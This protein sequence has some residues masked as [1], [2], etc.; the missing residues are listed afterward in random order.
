MNDVA[1]EFGISKK[2]LY[3]YFFDK[4]DLV[5]HVVDYFM[6]PS[7]HDLNSLAEANAIDSMLKIRK[8]VVYILKFYNNH[9]EDDLK[10]TYPNIYKEVYETKR[11]RI[12]DYT[13]KNLNRGIVQGL[14]R[15]D[16]TPLFVAKLQLGQMLYTLNPAYTIF[17]ESEIS[18]L[19]LFNN[20]MNYYMHAICTNKGFEYYTKQLNKVQD[21]NN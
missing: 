4:Q 7:N 15:Q 6:E 12:F 9:I 2:T 5:S 19:S 18:S 11:K 10:R 8:H 17:T 13:V 21:E 16:I 14:Y 20:M 1:T 3:Q